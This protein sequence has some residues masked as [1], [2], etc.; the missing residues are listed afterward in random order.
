[1]VRAGVATPYNDLHS[2]TYIGGIA[3]ALNGVP[4]EGC[5]SAVSVYGAA[6]PVEGVTYAT[7]GAFGRIRIHTNITNIIAYGSVLRGPENYIGNFAGIVPEGES[8]DGT[9]KDNNIIVR[10]FSSIDNIGATISQ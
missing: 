4:V 3:G 5:R 8:W 10:S 7:G 9:Y 2:S 1:M 6:S